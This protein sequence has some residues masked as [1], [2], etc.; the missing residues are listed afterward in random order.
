MQHLKSSIFA[1]VRELDERENKTYRPAVDVSS[2]YRRK[3]PIKSY[4]GGGH[5]LTRQFSCEKIGNGLFVT[6]WVNVSRKYVY[7]LFSQFRKDPY[8]RENK[9]SQAKESRANPLLKFSAIAQQRFSSRLLC[10]FDDTTRAR[11]LS[12][13]L[14]DCFCLVYVLSVLVSYTLWTAI[15]GIIWSLPSL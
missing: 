15:D 2:M 12:H 4:P 13:A 3:L 6:R 11:Y 8:V 14:S 10:K 5:S 9:V 1:S 7:R